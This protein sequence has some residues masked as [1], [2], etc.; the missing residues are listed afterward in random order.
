MK[1]LI[2][3]FICII[4]NVEHNFDGNSITTLIMDT[5]IGKEKTKDNVHRLKA[6]CISFFIL[7]IY[8]I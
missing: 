4:W 5:L 6:K 7:L 8:D 2:I 3:L 1:T